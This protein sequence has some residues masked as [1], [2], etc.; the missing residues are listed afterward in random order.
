MDKKLTSEDI[1]KA[2]EICTMGGDHGE[3]CPN[4]PLNNEKAAC[5]L[6]FAEYIINTTKPAFDW[7]GFI[8][9][10]FAVNLRTQK[11]YDAFMQECD[12]KG[13]KWISG[14][15]P[16]A[17]EKSWGIYE[18]NFCVR[19]EGGKISLSELAC[20]RGIDFNRDIPVFVYPDG[21]EITPLPAVTGM[22]TEASNDSNSAHPD[23]STLLDICQAAL[24]NISEGCGGNYSSGYAQATLDALEQ[25][26]G[27]QDD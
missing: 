18:E 9:G 16:T 14:A 27:E 23:D 11:D 5:V 3:L 20:Y 1:L 21:T 6:I 19:C 7:D 2:A 26:K 4:C 15:R 13:L 25:L 10:K 8:G 24:V 12:S 22:N 17:R